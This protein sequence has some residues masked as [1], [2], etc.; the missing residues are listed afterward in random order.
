MNFKQPFCVCFSN[1]VYSDC[2]SMLAGGER[3]GGGGGAVQGGGAERRLEAKYL[4]GRSFPWRFHAF[5]KSQ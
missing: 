2:F 1:F 4:K 3:G 5:Q